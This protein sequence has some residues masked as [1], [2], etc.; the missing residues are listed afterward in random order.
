[1]LL[2]VMGLPACASAQNLLSNGS[3]DTD[4]G[5]WQFKDATPTWSPMDIDGSPNSGS[6][7]AVNAQASSGTQLVVL[8]QCVPITLAGAYVVQAWGYAATGQA[9]G[10]LVGSYTL[11]VNH[12]DCSGGFVALGG[13]YI[14]SAGQWA[15]FNSG[16]IIVTYP[17]QPSMSINVALRV[18]KSDAGGSFAGYFDDV[19]LVRDTIFDGGFE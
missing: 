16:A 17:P 13:N 1:V 14:N 6:A 11:D 3:F 10:H 9:S 18:D 4:L 5:G 7:Y 2:V 15:S 8:S 19:S 12:T